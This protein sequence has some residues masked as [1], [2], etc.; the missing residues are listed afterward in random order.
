MF[1][2][3]LACWFLALVAGP[4]AALRAD[5]LPKVEDVELQPLSAQV[6][7]LVEASACSDSRCPPR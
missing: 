6:D 7:R 4:V 5:A 1:S 2:H 3:R